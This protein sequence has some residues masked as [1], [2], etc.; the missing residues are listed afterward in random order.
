M[1]ERGAVVMGCSAGGLK[2]LGV[3]LAGLVPSLRAPVILVC[4]TASDDVELLCQ[5]LQRHCA[6]P[7]R[8]AR[9]RHMPEAGVVYVAPSDYHLYLESSGDFAL[10]VD[11]KVSYCRPSI[12]VLFES[13]ADHYGKML[14]GVV[15]TGANSDGARGLTAIRQAGG[16]A[17]VQSPQEAEVA[18]MPEA[19]LALAGADHVAPLAEIA[20]LINRVCQ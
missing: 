18:T 5:L 8:E 16:L 20:A 12:D 17:L 4:H 11:A 6:L 13:A 15:L 10:S 3:L 9:E 7:V 19:A 14:V 1:A 2:A